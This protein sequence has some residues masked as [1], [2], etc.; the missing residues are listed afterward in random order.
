VTASRFASGHRE[1]AQRVVLTSSA[2]P[3][4]SVWPVSWIVASYRRCAPQLAGFRPGGWPR[5]RRP[6]GC[7]RARTG[8]RTYDLVVKG[9]D[10]ID[11]SRNR[12]GVRDIGIRAGRIVEIGQRIPAERADRR[13]EASGSLVMPGLV[14]MPTHIHPYGSAIGIP[15][16]E[17]APLNGTT[18]AVSA[19]NAGTNNLAGLR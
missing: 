16:D 14:D 15:P 2:R 1:L 8:A 17:L 19:G 18:T 12:R 13:L 10:V 6:R 3:C 11:P 9:G 7:V 5:S 4:D